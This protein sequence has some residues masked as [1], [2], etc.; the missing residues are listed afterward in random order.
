MYVW[1]M[2]VCVCIIYIYTYMCVYVRMS[3]WCMYV[4][5]HKHTMKFQIWNLFCRRYIVSYR[6]QLVHI[7]SVH[8][9]W[10]VFMP[11]H[12]VPTWHQGSCLVS[13]VFNQRVTAYFTSTSVVISLPFRWFLMGPKRWK[14][15]GPRSDCPKFLKN[16]AV[17]GLKMGDKMRP[18]DFYIYGPL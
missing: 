3:A 2:Y 17:T 16:C 11:L 6:W 13:R 4:W 1:C 9:F 10:T 15:P 7:S 5:I 12:F 18:S 8:Q 14:T